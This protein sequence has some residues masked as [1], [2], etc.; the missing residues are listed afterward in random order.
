MFYGRCFILLLTINRMKYTRRAKRKNSLRRKQTR[1]HSKARGGDN[2]NNKLKEIA[3]Y[4]SANNN[5]KDISQQLMQ[6]EAY[7]RLYPRTVRNMGILSNVKKYNNT[8]RKSPN[9]ITIPMPHLNLQDR[10]LTR[11]RRN[12]VTSNVASVVKS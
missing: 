2:R 4:A 8:I 6:T 1:R 3:T 11:S 10:N 12:A 7:K 9:Y 5:N